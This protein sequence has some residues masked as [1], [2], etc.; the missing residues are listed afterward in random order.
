MKKFRIF[1][2]L[3][4]KFF[5]ISFFIKNNG[6]SK[7]IC[8]KLN[9]ITRKKFSILTS[10]LRV[11]FYL[12]LKYLKKNNP[13]KNEVIISS[14]NLAE[15]VNIP[16]NLNLKPIFPKLNENIFLCSKDVKKKINKKTLA[17]VVTNIFNDNEDLENIKK[18]CRYKN[19]TLI[20]DNAI[21]FGNF[22][23]KKKLKVY[24][25]SYGDYSL[26]SFN[27]MKNLCGLYGGSVSTNN[28]EFLKFASEENETFKQFSF[29]KYI[30]QC[31]I[32]L[33]LKLLSNRFIYS[34]FFLPLI[35]WAHKNNNYTILKIIYPSLK[36]KKKPISKEYYTKI[37]NMS[38][39]LVWLQLKDFEN[40]E[41][42][43]I[44]R[45]EN[46]LFLFR[47]FK[48]SKIKQIKL[49][50]IKNPSFQ[51]FNDF[52]IIVK[53]KYELSN[54]LYSYGVETK[55]IQYVDCQK[56]FKSKAKKEDLY[57]NKILCFP[58]HKNISKEYLKF[59][60]SLTSKFYKN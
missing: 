22:T 7:K 10:Q 31:I 51:N 13:S 44:K 27:I 15:M 50:N 48:K 57:E 4:L 60:V 8:E 36:F 42:N 56:L 30:M 52:P 16:K 49:I 21:Y 37:T 17:V 28:T 33:I 59:I 47:E 2:Y 58:N 53:N 5:L 38:V 25:G 9:N 11:G 55:L 41:I 23:K 26:H 14:Y 24:S 18:V 54:F 20:E 43:R 3:R 32:F 29:I 45:K 46:N 12:V 39:K 34:L 19:V 1:I 35:K 6:F 40:F